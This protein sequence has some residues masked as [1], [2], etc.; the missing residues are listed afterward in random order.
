MADLYMSYY[1]LAIKD[2]GF[3]V[4]KALNNQGLR[5]GMVGIAPDSDESP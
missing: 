4:R 5:L 1:D 2:G 3:S